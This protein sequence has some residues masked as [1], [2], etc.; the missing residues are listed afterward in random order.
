VAD[1]EEI[2]W[3]SKPF[4]CLTI[5][6]RQRETIIAVT[7]TSPNLYSEFDDFVN[8]KRRDIIVLL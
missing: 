4:N 7:A 2:K 6:N 8:E 3:F 5:F 1:I